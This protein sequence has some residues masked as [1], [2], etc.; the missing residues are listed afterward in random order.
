LVPLHPKE[1]EMWR[2]LTRL[3]SHEGLPYGTEHVPGLG[4]VSKLPDQARWQLAGEYRA[5]HRLVGPWYRRSCAICGTRGGCEFSRWAIDVLT[6]KARV[7]W[8]R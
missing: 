5:A 7:E 8:G 3:V 6:E 2:R 1:A 4:A